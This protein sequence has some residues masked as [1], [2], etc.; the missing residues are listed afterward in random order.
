MHLINIKFQKLINIF[1]TLNI[2]ILDRLKFYFAVFFSLLSAFFDLLGVLILASILSVFSIESFSELEKIDFNFLNVFVNYFSISNNQTLLIYLILFYILKSFF[3]IIIN[4]INF[5]LIYFNRKKLSSFVISNFLKS[6]DPK[7]N[8]NIQAKFIR[9][10]TYGVDHVSDNSMVSIINLIKEFTSG[11]LIVS[12]LIININL[13]LFWIISLI[14]ISFF[15][16]I[17]LID[18]VKKL[19]D[20]IKEKTLLIVGFAKDISQSSKYIIVTNKVSYFLDK[21]NRLRNE[22]INTMTMYASINASIQPGIEIIVFI[23]LYLYLNIIS[24]TDNFIS[25]LSLISLSIVSLIRLIPIVS[26]IISSLNSIFYSL[27]YLNELS[28]SLNNTFNKSHSLVIKN[29]KNF[30]DYQIPD[31]YYTKQIFSSCNIRLC[32]NKINEIT[33][34][35]GSGKTSLL[36]LIALASIN[37]KINVAYVEQEPFFFNGTILENI[38]FEKKTSKKLLTEIIKYIKLLKLD[39]NFNL[40]SEDFLNY[41]LSDNAS[42]ISGGQRKKIALIREIIFKPHVLIL[43]EL[44]AGVDFD[45]LQHIILILKR[46]KNEFIILLSSHDPELKKISNNVYIINNKKITYL[47]G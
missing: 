27:P 4:Y 21:F 32:K 45:S 18:Y 23:L 29:H 22:Q 8:D 42:N 1:N 40:R 33:G 38:I 28:L 19:G 14:I 2:L 6:Y 3:Q 39:K 41:K 26:R 34:P 11:L 36:N 37:S 20:L 31:F 43:D 10:I 44:S 5:F 24:P 12:F 15:I 30:I 9:N 13:N 46:L 47:D 16:T 25:Y 35:S 17:F 7:K